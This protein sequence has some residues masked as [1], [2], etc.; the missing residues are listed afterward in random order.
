MYGFG[1][2]LY[3]CIS[4][5]SYGSYFLI[6]IPVLKNISQI[7]AGYYHSLALNSSGTVFSF[8]Y[9]LYGQ[10][11]NGLSSSQTQFPFLV[12]NNATSIDISIYYSVAINS[13][14]DAFHFGLNP[15]NSLKLIIRII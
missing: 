13:S 3:F 11:G 10:T 5:S 4:A 12:M 6:P 7:K 9:N 15:V 1:Y 14:G 2:N 8:G